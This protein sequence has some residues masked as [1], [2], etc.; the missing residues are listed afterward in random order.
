MSET[1]DIDEVHSDGVVVMAIRAIREGK[2]AIS[3]L[4]Q[5][6]ALAW[7]VYGSAYNL[8]LHIDFEE[9]SSDSWVY[10]VQKY[11]EQRKETETGRFTDIPKGVYVLSY[12]E[13]RDKVNRHGD[14]IVFI[15]KESTS[16][17]S[18]RTL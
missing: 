10:F 1:V 16:N 13:Y 9:A 14:D 8:Y 6:A 12:K 4:I 18:Q 7:T 17:A 15:K 11:I 3:F 2:K 5:N